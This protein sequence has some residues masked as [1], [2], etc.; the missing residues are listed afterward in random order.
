MDRG[1]WRATGHKGSDTT[2]QLSISPALPLPTSL[3]PL[4]TTGLFSTSVSLFL[5]FLL[6]CPRVCFLF[7]IP[8]M[9]DI[10]PYFPFV[11]Q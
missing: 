4:I 3:S 11:F 5:F 2:E 10:M 9:S 1:A 8:R 6:L 7:Q